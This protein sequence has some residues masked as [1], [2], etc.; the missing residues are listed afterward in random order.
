MAGIE[1]VF[2]AFLVV[3]LAH[4]AEE[5]IYPG[6]FMDFMRR[7]NPDLAPLVTRRFAGVINGLQILLCI[8]GI[9][10]GR[11]HLAFSLSVGA[12]LFV[13]GLVHIAAGAKLKTYVP[14]V[15]T[16][17]VLYLPVSA[18]AYYAFAASGQ[19]HLRQGIISGLLGAL[20]QAVPISYL[21]LVRAARR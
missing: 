7:L 21:G 11:S 15:I 12:L 10:V 4:M 20:Y 6:G 19:L 8:L 9:A 2:W 1:R 3:S 5:Y 18:Y 16:G 17:G 13:N 14:G